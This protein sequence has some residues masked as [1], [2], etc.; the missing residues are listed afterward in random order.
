M[1]GPDWPVS[2]FSLIVPSSLEYNWISVTQ[3]DR[4]QL[5]KLRWSQDGV[6][7]QLKV[8]FRK[9]K[10][11]STIIPFAQGDGIL[12]LGLV[13]ARAKLSQTLI[14]LSSLPQTSTSWMSGYQPQK[15]WHTAPSWPCRLWA[16]HIQRWPPAGWPGELPLGLEDD[17]W[18]PLH[19]TRQTSSRRSQQT[20]YM[21]FLRKGKGWKCAS[22]WILW[23]AA[24]KPLPPPRLEDRSNCQVQRKQEI[25]PT[26]VSIRHTQTFNAFPSIDFIDSCEGW[27]ASL[28]A[29]L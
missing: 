19:L 11:Y 9:D 27:V 3:S 4:Q 7:V 23:W 28:T 2:Y 1:G 14:W 5:P 15:A 16:G 8:E 21:S 18:P 29:M 6:E 17:W 20:L 25:A 22:P 13:F 12:I 24:A 10:K 26:I